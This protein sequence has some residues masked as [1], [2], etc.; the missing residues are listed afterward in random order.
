MPC[1]DDYYDDPRN[2]QRSQLSEAQRTAKNLQKR[3]DELAAENCA[4]RAFICSNYDSIDTSKL[5][6]YHAGIFKKAIKDQK[7]HRGKDKKRAMKSISKGIDECRRRV[8]QIKELG[9]IPS[10]ELLAEI[11]E[12]QAK[13]SII[14]KS[15]PMATD[16]Y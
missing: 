10:D 6:D 14:K 16:L 1:R 8:T 7:I 2:M 5:S 12:Y 9:G 3:N 13:L 4:L 11:K 15:D